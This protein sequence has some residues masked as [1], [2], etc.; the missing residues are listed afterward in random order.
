MRFFI[1]NVENL[2]NT[3]ENWQNLRELPVRGLYILA[4]SFRFSE[5]KIDSRFVF[6]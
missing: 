2:K 4:Q 3:A 6:R 1:K 5:S